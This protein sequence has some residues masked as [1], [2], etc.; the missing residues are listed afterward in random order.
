MRRVLTL[1][2]EIFRPN[3]FILGAP[4]TGTTSLAQWLK[5]HPQV[6][7]STP[8][9]PDFFG[10]DIRRSSKVSLKQYE[11]CFTGAKSSHIAIGEA[12]TNYLRSRLAISEI[13]AYSPDAR[14][15]VGLRN[16]VEMAISLHNQML[17]NAWETEQNFE[18]AWRLQ[19]VRREG[20]K[21]PWLCPDPS[22]LQYG[23]LCLLGR[24]LEHLYAHVPKSRVF[25]YTVDEM[26]ADTRSLW[27]RVQEFLGVDDDQRAVFPVLNEARQIPRF[28]NTVKRLTDDFK[29]KVGLSYQYSGFFDFL[30]RY[31]SSEK[32]IKVRK[33][34]RV[35]LQKYFHEDVQRLSLLSGK[36]LLNWSV[37]TPVVV[38]E[39]PRV[40]VV[41]L[42]WNGCQDTLACLASLQNLT[43]PN[44]FA[45]VVDNASS[46]NSEARIRDAYPDVVVLQSGANLGFAGGNNLGIN[47]ALDRGAS[48]VWIL[49]NDT[50]VEPG[51][52]SALVERIQQKNGAGLCGSTLVYLDERK[53][54]QALGGGRY[55]KWV[56]RTFH[57]G[58]SRPL[59]ALNEVDVSEV[60]SDLDS[61]VGA[62]MLVSRSF[63]EDVGLL[64]TD[65]FLYCEELDWARRGK[66]WYSLA[67]ARQSIVFHKEGASTGGSNQ[68]KRERSRVSEYH[69]IRSRLV[70]TMKHY[71]Y[72]FPTVYAATWLTLMKRIV[73]L[74]FDRVPMIFSLLM[75]NW[76]APSGRR[77]GNQAAQD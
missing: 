67:Y 57:V 42:N 66:E 60:E 41:I 18:R 43:Y 49:N 64:S 63:I 62:S 10:A 25:V 6:W 32:A 33:G 38:R 19:E 11:S 45:V 5:E 75:G 8:K 21:I 24:Q 44:F 30:S 70:F 54:V 37:D 34:F 53:I 31:M 23:S 77:D 68:R 40:G 4:K 71:P 69:S 65:F 56:G 48:Y 20:R 46:D 1:S 61:I 52:L 9:E 51:A 26:R 55:N 17:I 16:P 58:E 47:C 28:L 29:G 35:E 2:P 39:S 12:S 74:K 14:F 13:L 59:S 27:Q 3:F 73:Y 7:I 22:H 15:I 72:A 76:T 36:D 50:E